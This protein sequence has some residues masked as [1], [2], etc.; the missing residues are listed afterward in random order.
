MLAIALVATAGWGYAQYQEKNNYY[1]HLENQ[2]QRLYYDLTG[3]VESITTDLSKLM[4][5]SPQKKENLILYSNIWKNAYNAQE[6]LAQLPIRHAE[7]SKVQKFLNQLGDYTFAMAQ[8]TFQG[9]E[10][11]DKER[12][13]L[14]QLHNYSLELT[15]SLR[16]LH[17]KVLKDVV[18][19]DELKRK[20]NT[21]LNEDAEKQNPIQVK[22][23]Q[24]EERMVEYPELIYDGP[25]SDHVSEGVR[26]RLKGKKV[27]RET[28]EKKVKEF[29]GNAKIQ[30]VE[31]LT[32]GR[33]R[34]DT[35]SFE[36]IPQNKAD[37]KGN[38]VYID[39]SQTNGYVAWILNNRDIK[40]AKLSRKQA[41]QR[42]SKFLEEKGYKI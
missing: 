7:I 27:S 42:A 9:E 16:E 18:W 39:I 15:Q 23:A 14:E 31:S 17:E 33:G 30:R 36:V 40:E 6:K 12:G 1:I 37:G 32:D 4:V 35:Y 11:Q 29:L 5:S 20:A 28:A 2:Y 10:L 3:S 22:F 26:P 38:P 25:F 41:V 21:K 8:R 34:V 13:N 19:K 24:F